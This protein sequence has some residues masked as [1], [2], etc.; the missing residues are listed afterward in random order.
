MAPPLLREGPR[1]QSVVTLIHDTADVFG[2]PRHATVERRT[3]RPADGP[4][5][6]ILFDVNDVAGGFGR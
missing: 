2:V 6:S 1:I 4:M 5:A 3:A